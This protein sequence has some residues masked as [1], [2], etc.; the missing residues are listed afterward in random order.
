MGVAVA[1]ELLAEGTTVFV[2]GRV[3]VAPIL[4]A[5][6][7]QL[8][9]KKVARNTVPNVERKNCLAIFTSPV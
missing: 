4:V 8:T 7:A 2:G 3:G 9:R 6:E 5:A 1:L